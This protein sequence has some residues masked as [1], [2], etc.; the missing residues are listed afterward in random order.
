MCSHIHISIFQNLKQGLFESYYGFEGITYAD[1][2]DTINMCVINEVEYDFLYFIDLDGSFRPNTSIS[3]SIST[4][5]ASDNK[6]HTRFL[7]G[8]TCV[9]NAAGCYSYCPNVCF[10][11]VRYV[12]TGPGQ[13][14]Y[15][16]KVCRANDS[17]RCSLFKGGR[18][19]TS[20]PHE[21]TAHLPP[22]TYTA[23][24][25]NAQGQ[26]IT[27]TTVVGSLEHTY[28]PVSQL[29]VTMVGVNLSPISP[30][31]SAPVG[32]APVTVRPAPVRPPSTAPAPVRPPAP[33]AAPVRPPSAPI[34]T[35]AVP[36]RAPA[37]TKP[38]SFLDMLKK[39]L[40]V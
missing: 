38:L 35:G 18:R 4:L 25:L 1:G 12:V 37:P 24:F 5:V 39:L 16:L 28:C 13:A 10:R 27:P 30:S 6:E 33:R 21:F 31:S 26:V 34:G 36:V 20:G 17:S 8:V 23:V 32:T 9:D 7:D 15:K 40:G 2:P 22:G 3:P 11:S 19:E 29:E 14:S